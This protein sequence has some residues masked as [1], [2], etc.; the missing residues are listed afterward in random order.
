ME[1]PRVRR[2]KSVAIVLLALVLAP[3]AWADVKLPTLF[4]DHMV[5]QRDMPLPV[6]GWADPGEEVTVKLCGKEVR[7]KA[8]DKGKW[9]VKLD[10]LPAGG[11]HELTV[12]GKNTITIQDVLVGEV[13]VGSGQS[14]MALTVSRTANAEQDVADANYPKIR[15]FK[16]GMKHAIE[17]QEECGGRWQVCSPEVAGN[18]SGTAY[19]FA[20]NLYKHL[21]VPIGILQSAIGGTSAEAWT[22]REGF[23]SNPDLRKILEQPEWKAVLDDFD[24][25]VK[26]H[27]EKMKAWREKTAALRKE[28]KLQDVKKGRRRPPR[29]KYK[30][31]P[32]LLYN[33]MIAPLIPYAIRGAIW[34]Q[35][36]RNANGG[37]S[38]QY[39]VLLPAMIGSWRKAW[40]QGDF[41]FLFVQLPNFRA[42][43]PEPS[44]SAWA[45]IRESFLKSLSTP[46][47]GM[48]VTI[49]IGEAKDIHPKN[50]KDVGDRLARWAWAMV[51]GEK[52]VYSGPL[53]ESMAVEGNKIRVKFTHIGSGLTA[54]GGEPLKQFAIAG[55]DKKFVW[56]EAKVDGDTVLIWSGKVSKPVAARYAWA[57]NPEG[58]NLFNKEGLPAS[59]FRT[60]DWPGVT[61]AGK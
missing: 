40:K 4:S 60:D 22:S 59:P 23:E 49:D 7:T 14:N 2:L 58:C 34:Y 10:A 56:A 15:F 12:S 21:N 37:R 30:N 57:D 39:A 51:Y 13:W 44:E 42:V 17:P 11:P 53:Y 6:W 19:F 43:Q 9:M 45:E 5:L 54:K 41:P 16:V 48:A 1:K 38:K 29:A 25:A 35:G 28:G 3:A 50:K 26:Q 33:G 32:T 24:G 18:F 47:T 52:G 61:D 27:Q 20:R 55:E 31:A 8:D 36:E 46:N